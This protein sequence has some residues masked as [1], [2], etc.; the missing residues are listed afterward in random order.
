MKY[1]SFVLLT[2]LCGCASP[3]Q[4]DS[5]GRDT[6]VKVTNDSLRNPAKDISS[7]KKDS[8]PRS[9]F[10][11]IRL[12]YKLSN[13]QIQSKTLIDSS[14]YTG[15]Y[16]RAKFEGDT[17]FTIGNGF[18]G[19]IIQY[20]DRTNCLYKFLLIFDSADRNTDYK[21]IFSNCDRDESADY[22]TLDYRLQNDTVFQI[23]ESIIPK[24]SD[25]VSKVGKTNWLINKEGKIDLIHKR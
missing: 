5:H 13:L 11:S 9:F 23:Q 6:L 21:K 16:S 25:K 14:Y 3:T 17:V 2:M 10:D 12:R 7:S 18:K 4:N 15:D 20:D 8:L 1:I 24:N 22:Y 19:I